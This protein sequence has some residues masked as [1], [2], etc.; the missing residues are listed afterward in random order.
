MWGQPARLR[1]GVLQAGVLN[2]MA[3][4]T[5]EKV[6]AH[7]RSKT[8]FWGKARRGGVECHRNLPELSE[9]G[10]PLVQ[11]MG[12][13]KP[14]AQAMGNQVPLVWAMGSQATPVWLG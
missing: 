14:L 10:A 8:P 9:G 4:G 7:R 11:A 12:G 2:I 3:Q 13:K 6:W 1:T 5:Q